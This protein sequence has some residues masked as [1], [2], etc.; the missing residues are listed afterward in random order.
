MRRALEAFCHDHGA[1]ESNLARSLK[2]LA[3]GGLLDQRL[4]NWANGLKALGN[5]G[6]HA[7]ET[8]VDRRDAKDALELADAILE[9]VYVFTVKYEEFAAR[10]GTPVRGSS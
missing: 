7:S 2:K 4:F 10:R 8:P 6:A 9:Y 3:D 1:T 5:V